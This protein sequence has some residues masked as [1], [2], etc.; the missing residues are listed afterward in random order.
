MDVMMEELGRTAPL[1]LGAAVVPM[2]VVGGYFAIALDRLR[3][4][5]ATAG[6]TQVGLKL[7]LHALV[8]FGV[9]LAVGNVERLVAMMLG[10]FHDFVATI[11][12]TLAGALVGGGTAAVIGFIV[13]PRTNA[14]TARQPERFALGLLALVYGTL[15]MVLVTA[16]LDDLVQSAA[17][18]ETSTALANAAISAVVAVI[19]INRFG[20]RAGWASPPAVLPPV[21]QPPPPGLGGGGYPPPQAGGYYGPPPGGGNPYQPR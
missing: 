17:W 15:A 6:D 16:T 10:G 9:F 21:P 19:A 7:V 1:A 14:A 5:S 4:D 20:S 2:Y 8:L 18:A 11:K 12:A 3:K 13:L